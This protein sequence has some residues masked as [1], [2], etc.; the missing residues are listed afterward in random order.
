M[1]AHGA[2]VPTQH[3]SRI[4]ATDGANVFAGSNTTYNINDGDTRNYF[5]QSCI[6]AP[7]L[8]LYLSV[9]RSRQVSVIDCGSTAY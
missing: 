1:A 8:T 6:A 5:F 9:A 4:T 7:T 3:I 2:Y